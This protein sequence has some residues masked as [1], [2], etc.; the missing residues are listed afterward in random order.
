[1]AVRY[2]EDFYGW[3]QEQAKLLKAGQLNAVD[4]EH[5]AEEIESM[6]VSELREL[7]SRLEA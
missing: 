4:L 1:M 7:T 3:R 5:I 2:Q 6:G